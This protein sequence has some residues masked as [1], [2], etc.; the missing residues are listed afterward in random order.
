MTLL[1]HRGHRFSRARRS[2]D[3]SR[4]RAQLRSAAT[5]SFSELR[6]EHVADYRSYADRCNLRLLDGPDPLR[7]MATD[8]RMERLKNGGEDAG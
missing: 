1:P 8:K 3:D 7:A 6:R 4:L 2:R 5:R